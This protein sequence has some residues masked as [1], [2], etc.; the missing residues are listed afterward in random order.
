[1]LKFLRNKHHQKKIYIILATAIIPPFLMWGVTTSQKESK[2][3]STLGLIENKKISLREYLNSYK[4]VQHEMAFMVG[5]RSKEVAQAINIKG[6]AWD[7]IL[8]LYQA[9]KEKI[10][11][12]DAE[13]V[14]WI[15]RQPLFQSHGQFDAN[16][17]DLYVARYLRSNARDFEEEIRDSLTIEKIADMIRSHATVKDE[18]LKTLYKQAN[19]Q[20]DFVYDDKK[21]EAE[22]EIFRKKMTDQKA[23]EGMKALLDKLRNELK[24]DLEAMRKIFAEEKTEKPVA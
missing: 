10:R 11:T 14:E 24:I 12:G 3:P 22:K 16:V 19:N 13:V 18:E 2:V 7:R 8:L 15:S 20:K 4:A 6:E 21:F 5:E 1:M 17:Y 9:K 23:S